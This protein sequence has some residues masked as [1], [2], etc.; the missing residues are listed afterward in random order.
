[1]ETETPHDTPRLA[2]VVARLEAVEQEQARLQRA[3]GRLA[4]HWARLHA[5]SKAAR[6]AAVT[7]H[8]RRSHAVTVGLRIASRGGAVA[9]ASTEGPGLYA[10][11]RDA[12]AVVAS[13]LNAHGVH[14]VGGGVRGGLGTSPGP[15]GVFAE[16]GGG[17]GLYATSADVAVHGVSTAG[18]GASFAGGSAPLHLVPATSVGAPVTGEY[19]Q[20]TLYVDAAGTLWLCMAGGRPGTWKQVVVR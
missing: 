17:D 10:E 3:L 12:A 15:C 14:A 11:S 9:A 7:R 20:G 13:S 1:M 6:R 4:A 2:A 19:R 16:G 18:Y 8:G 5:A